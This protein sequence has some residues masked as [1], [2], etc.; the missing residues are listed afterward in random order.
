MLTHRLQ[1]TLR[2]VGK[3]RYRLSI[4]GYPYIGVEERWKDVTASL[5]REEDKEWTFTYV[6]HQ[7]GFL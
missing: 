2:K 7:N 5:R 4:G 3:N 1:W 6:E